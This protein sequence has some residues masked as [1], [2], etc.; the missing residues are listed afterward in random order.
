M[1]ST[2]G[3]SLAFYVICTLILVILVT[4][5]LTHVLPGRLAHEINDESEAFPIAI[6]FCA[7]VQLLWRPAGFDEGRRWAIAVSAA[8]VCWLTAWLL[9]TLP[10]PSSLATLNESFVAVGAMILYACLPRPVRFPL[11]LGTVA[12]ALVLLFNS[13][14]FVTAQAESM[15][16]IALMP[17]AFDWADRTILDP[18][19]QDAPWRRAAWYVVLV[20]VPVVARAH[21]HLGS[22]HDV[23]HYERRATE[24]FLGLLLVHLYFSQ[25]LG[26]RWRSRTDAIEGRH[27]GGDLSRKPLPT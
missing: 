18:N 20:A 12:V 19:A 9:L 21:V 23:F 16:P 7:Y 11:L 24:G 2:R 17:F 13:T 3:R 5:S 10:L 4:K 26:D 15:V 14:H 22:V 1:S 25:V 6:L 27:I 8:A